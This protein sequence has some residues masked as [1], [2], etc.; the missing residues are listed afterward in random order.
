MRT[1]PSMQHS[2]VIMQQN[3]DTNGIVF[4]SNRPTTVKTR[5]IGNKTQMLRI[6]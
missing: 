2:D 3:M 1:A 5:I 6:D 4:S